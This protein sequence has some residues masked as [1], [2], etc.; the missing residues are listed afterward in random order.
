[1]EQNNVVPEC[2][3]FLGFSFIALKI[4]VAE[5]KNED[6]LSKRITVFGV[7]AGMIS[8]FMSVDTMVA[9][10][11]GM[12]VRSVERR[13]SVTQGPFQ[14]FLNGYEKALRQQLEQERVPGAAWAVVKD[15]VVAAIGTYGVKSTEARDS[16]TASTLFRIASLSKGVTGVLAGRLVDAGLIDWSAPYCAYAPR[17]TGHIIEGLET[18]ELQHFLTHTTG[19]PRHTYSN[20]L[21]LGRSY[22]NILSLLPLVKQVHPP[23]SYHNYQNVLFNLGAD[24]LR[25]STGQ[26]FGTLAEEWLF[27]PLGMYRASVGYKPFVEDMDKAMPHRRLADGYAPAAVEPNFYE[28]PGAAGVNASIT[29]MAKWLVAVSG[30]RPGV[31][32]ERVLSEVLCPAIPIPAARIMHRNWNGL[33]AGYYAM[34]WRVFEIDDQWIVGH[35]G[36]VNGFRAEIAF[37]PEED[38]GVV[39]L[40]NAPNQTVGNAVPHFF[41]LYK[42]QITG[43]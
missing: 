42:E 41:E 32:P 22:S 38:I 7:L 12:V 15:G 20:L 19:L 17:R 18:L 23:G 43:P 31:L 4:A 10:G 2:I 24:M 21:N 35:S 33:Q 36:Y 5:E 34:G 14:S 27:E 3:R 40:T 29:D 9:E 26:A 28:V 37:L 16:V 25:S 11:G 39:L 6:M 13:A 8:L 1:L 30:H